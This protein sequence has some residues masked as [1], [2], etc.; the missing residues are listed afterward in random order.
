MISLLSWVFSILRYNAQHLQGIVGTMLSTPIVDDTWQIGMAQ[1]DVVLQHVVET[2]LKILCAIFVSLNRANRCAQVSV[3]RRHQ[4]CRLG[5]DIIAGHGEIASRRF[6]VIGLQLH[7]MTQMINDVATRLQ[8][9]EEDME[10]LEC[11][12]VFGAQVFQQ[13]SRVHRAAT[14][15]L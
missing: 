15:P 7:L 9:V 13:G 12:P 6:N 1:L 8:A 14:F 4:C 3:E 11:A 2:D 5:S 10:F